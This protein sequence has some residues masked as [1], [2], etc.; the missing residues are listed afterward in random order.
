MDMIT[1]ARSAWRSLR[2]TPAFS[3]VAVTV[4]ALGIG[5]STAVFSVVNQVLLEPL[6]YA[7]P[8]QLVRVYQYRLDTPATNTYVAAPVF[9]ELR[10]MQ[11]LDDAAA[12][13]TYSELGADLSGSA[14][15][16][17]VR[18]LPVSAAYF[19]VLRAQPVLGRGF[20]TDEERTPGARVVVLSH[21]L[22]QRHYGG[23]RTVVG[24]TLVMSGEPHEIIGVAPSAL[25]DPVVGAVDLWVPH[26]VDPNDHP[27]N[28]SLTVIARLR[29]GTTLEQA[30]AELSHLNARLAAHYDAGANR[31]TRML[32]L[33][34]ATVAGASRM[35]YVLLG[36]VGLVLLIVCVDIANLMLARASTREREFA[37]RAALGSGRA[38]IVQQLLLESVILAAAGGVAG[39]ILGS[40]L[41][42]AIVALG[43]ASVPRLAGTSFD[44]RVLAFAA[45][46]TL[47]CALFVGVLP[48][49]RFS[50][51]AA[52][53]VLRESARNVTTD[54]G[55][56]RVRTILVG[57]QVALAFMLLVGASILTL[58]LLR[59][60][61]V[62]LGIAEDGAL[63][64]EVHL[65]IARYDDAR[66]AAFHEEFAIRVA[67]LA[68]VQAVGG[69]SRLPATGSY[70]GWGSR[71][72]TGPLAGSNESLGAE[73]RVVSGD[74]FAA[75]R[76]P[77]V[78]GRLFDERD[79]AAVPRRVVISA[80]AAETMFPGVDAVGQKL[81]VLGDTV[82][83]I[84]VVG[85]VAL[86]P[87]GTHK[88]TV[89][90]AHRQFAD[91][92]NWALTQVVRASTDPTAL[93]PAIRDV[94]AELDPELVL[95]RPAPLADVLGQGIAQ[96]RFT[97]AL[98]SAF[99][100]LAVLL[101]TIG[102]FGVITYLVR[103]RRR[104]MGIRAAL[105]ARPAQIR[106]L[107][108][109]QGLHIAGVGVAAGLAGAL[110]GSRALQSLV[111]E[112][113]P[114]DPRVLAVT[115]LGMLAVAALA[116]YLP[117]REATAVDPAA[118]LQD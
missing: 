57:A 99:A 117:A 103:Q 67:A 76:I 66:R 113:R 25:R 115:A 8:G 85:D 59:L 96:R 65:P 39:V 74:Y 42:D 45:T 40:F 95:H 97:T 64:F 6:P 98:M 46:V 71:P 77:L 22:W 78:T 14:G 112:T 10:G 104:E 26:F 106:A 29:S 54:R 21:D 43:A 116:T 2:R 91:N 90:H 7:Q 4:L 86:T 50:R 102:L 80:L 9:T 20:L 27:E 60:R 82:E 89:Y 84:G 88:A 32:R 3:V 18:R 11:T 48:A 49:L 81:R 13:Y 63:T 69:V 72:A 12:I 37:V 44:L 41:L 68:G 93:V 109:K 118:T 79:N 30:R 101:A 17:R 36:A 34:D 51:V 114:A 47:G 38:R 23:S 92:R 28:H 53:G 52:A 61:S 83:V 108:L 35:L 62:D 31:P 111:F 73:Q 16:E 100:L 5:G 75:M 70:H 94:L 87:E 56:N 105:G 24:Q 107:V 33:H 1:P 19:D 15:V 58:S 55:R 110:V